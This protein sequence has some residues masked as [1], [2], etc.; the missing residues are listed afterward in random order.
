MLRL[1]SRILGKQATSPTKTTLYI[2]QHCSFQASTA[3]RPSASNSLRTLGCYRG[4]HATASLLRWSDG[5]RQSR[6]DREPY[7]PRKPYGRPR[8]K[9]SKDNYPDEDRNLQFDERRYR[10]H[11]SGVRGGGNRRGEQDSSPDLRSIV[12][13][14][15]GSR[16]ADY[17][18]QL[19]KL[20]REELEKRDPAMQVLKTM[21]KPETFQD[22]SLRPIVKKALARAY[23]NIT[24]MSQSQRNM[25]LLLQDGYSL[26]A[27][28]PPGSGKSFTAA[29]WLLQT[30]RSIKSTTMPDGTTRRTPS[31]T[32]IVFVPTIDLLFQWEGWLNNLVSAF[33]EPGQP[34]IPKETIF[35]AFTRLSPDQNA[36]E[37]AQLQRLQKFPSPHIIVTTP[38]RFMDIL[39]DP[40]TKY[41]IDPKSLKVIIADEVDAMTTQRPAPKSL[42]DMKKSS[43]IRDQYKW[44]KPTPF[45]LCMDRLL[46]S[47]DV[48]T[49]M[50]AN[51]EPL[52]PLQYCFISPNLSPVLQSK[53]LYQ[54]QWVEQGESRQNQLL[55]LGIRDFSKQFD[56]EKIQTNVWLPQRIKH[57]AM[58][59]D[60]TSGM[61]RDIPASQGDVLRRSKDEQAEIAKYI[62]VLKCHHD[63]RVEVMSNQALAVEAAQENILSNEEG[64]LTKFNYFAKTDD[65]EDVKDII[66]DLRNDF[67]HTSLPR[68]LVVEVLDFLLKR[69][70]Y[71]ERVIVYF[72][73]TVS[74]QE[75]IDALADAGFK[76]DY[77]RNDTLEAAGVQL[78]RSDLP[79]PQTEN[80][81]RTRSDTT[82][83]VASPHAVRG[84]DLPHFTHA[85]IMFPTTAYQKYAQMAGR[86]ARYPFPNEVPAMPEPKG[87]VTTVFLEEPVGSHRFAPMVDGVIQIGSPVEALAWRRIHRMYALCGAKVDNYF[88]ED[89]P[90]GALLKGVESH[91][92][93]F[94]D[95]DEELPW[96][97]G[98]DLETQ[99]Q[100]QSHAELESDEGYEFLPMDG[101]SPTTEISGLVSSQIKHETKQQGQ[102]SVEQDES[103]LEDSFEPIAVKRED[104]PVPVQTESSTSAKNAEVESSAESLEEV[105]AEE[106]SPEEEA[107]EA[108]TRE[109][110]NDPE[111]SPSIY[112]PVEL[113]DGAHFAPEDSP[114]DV[115]PGASDETEPSVVPPELKGV[116]EDPLD[117]A[118]GL[119]EE[120]VKEFQ[121]AQDQIFAAFLE[122]N[123]IQ[124]KLRQE[125]EAKEGPQ[126][127]KTENVVDE[128]GEVADLDIDR[129]QHHTVPAPKDDD[130]K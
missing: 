32:A 1:N 81:T 35:Q 63:P 112:E 5:V 36:Q 118:E 98:V 121:E 124:D 49:S 31:N 34:A 12:E 25:L 54:K 46:E 37:I 61:M 6:P 75:Y 119:S 3:L 69:D 28:G 65:Q 68:Q 86:I 113:E 13:A 76:A 59:V 23:P 71:P 52:E 19:H 125:K 93:K 66:T 84:L 58:S 38:T 127:S 50:F 97:A 109:D 77:I 42:A 105:S 90:Y 29:L 130:S 72:T 43:V 79:P 67:R 99:S 8:Y 27:T 39:N 30:M 85:Y 128:D 83:W 55:N 126:S 18:Q 33:T 60:I 20:K 101:E 74:R 106:P 17:T 80:T 62:N 129:V 96:E 100:S 24:A 16:D 10:T 51:D 15:R 45:E 107:I 115:T 7:K 47:R 110:E 120:E 11:D 14:S 9:N 73:P 70:N 103:D 64:S 48:G 111:D 53:I 116:G 56:T 22:A 57:Y 89:E 94:P 26:C 108:E 91:T 2:C 82:I 123:A 78:G 104:G 4:Y 117:I 102:E 122:L 92:T 88:R 44:A 87:Q 41:L 114:G 95:M 40:H 21:E